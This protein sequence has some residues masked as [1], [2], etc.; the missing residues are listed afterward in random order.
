MFKCHEKLPHHS[1]LHLETLCIRWRI[2]QKMEKPKVKKSFEMIRFH[3]LL[4]LFCSL[5]SWVPDSSLLSQLIFSQQI[6]KIKTNTF[7]EFH[8]F[9]TL[10]KRH[11]LKN[12][13]AFVDK[14]S[15]T[16]LTALSK[17]YFSYTKNAI[18]GHFCKSL[19]VYKVSTW[20]HLQSNDINTLKHIDYY[21]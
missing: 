20:Q 14:E 13:S 6:S 17:N 5:S 4:Y 1:N 11:F 15:S 2:C 8:M 16:F 3:T 18:S 12:L 19:I 7:F 9:C 10:Q 21:S